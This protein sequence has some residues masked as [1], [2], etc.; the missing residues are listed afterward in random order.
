MERFMEHHRFGVAKHSLAIQLAIN[1]SIY[2]YTYVNTIERTFLAL[3]IL[4]VGLI[5]QGKIHELETR[6]AVLENHSRGPV[7]VLPGSHESTF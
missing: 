2:V 5:Q 6:M 4:C 3:I 7:E 1:V